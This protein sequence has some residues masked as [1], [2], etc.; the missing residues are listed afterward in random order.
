M[1]TTCLVCF[2]AERD[3]ANQ[4]KKYGDDGRGL[5]LGIQVLNETPP[6][7]SRCGLVKIE[8]SEG[9]WRETV[10]RAFKEICSVLSRARFLTH[11]IVLGSKA[12][13]RIATHASISAK[14]PEWAAEREYR[15][16]KL[17]FDDELLK[18][19]ERESAGKTLRY[20][21]VPVRVEGKRIALA[22]VIIG[23]NQNAEDARERLAA[24]LAGNGYV[25]ECPEYPD[26]AVLSIS[27]WTY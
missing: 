25:P 14:H 24:L 18:L 15:L 26:I 20:L 3:D 9:S 1:L 2:S 8:Y 12:L 13:Y 21:P 27:P 16:V 23:P 6:T 22:E 4:W 19:R 7:D 10:T 11:N 17:V 5:C